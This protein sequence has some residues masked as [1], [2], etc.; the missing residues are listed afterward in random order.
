MK[1]DSF[2]LIYKLYETS[3][4]AVKTPMGL[5]KRRRVDRE[6]ITQ[7]DCLGPIL[8]SSSVDTFGKECYQKQKHLYWYRNQTPL[9]VLSMIDDV[10]AISNCGPESLQIQEFL[11]IKT[12]SKKLQYATDKTFRMHIG[13]KNPA[14]KCENTY[15]DSWKQTK[16][17]QTMFTETYEGRIKVKQVFKTKYLGEVICSDGSN[18]ANISNRKG[19]GFGTVKEIINMLDKMCLGPYMF[20]K[21]LVLR[22][23]MLVGTL[24]S[25]SEVWYN[26]SEGELCQLEQV[27]KSLWCQLLEVARTIPYDLLCLELGIEPLRFIIMRRRLTYL[28]HILKQTDNSLVKKFLRTQNMNPKKKDWIST[29]KQNLKQLDITLT[30][31]NIEEMPKNTY[32]K[33]IK[34]KIKKEA[35][36]YLVKKRDERNGKGI[37]ILYQ[38]LDMQTYLGSEDID[39]TNEE[40]KLIFQLRTKMCFKIKTHFRNMYANTICEGCHLNEST[41]K[42]T[43]E[44]VRLI[45]RN[46]IVTYLPSYHD[47]YGEDEDEQVYIARIIKDN[48][49]RLPSY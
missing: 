4:V 26:V 19:R 13:K 9:S 7:G 49:S 28:Q 36:S 33:I 21:A 2:A 5:T 44:C 22:D 17:S 3:N 47:I 8:A 40:R 25:C 45:G 14:F 43:L 46:E 24:L 30:L 18:T 20:K 29:V 23:S 48:I 32:K 37:E 31:Q 42:H 27:D 10:F 12:G 16:S 15:I 11:N 39:I 1:D 6:I 41:T 35:F 38:N 34:N